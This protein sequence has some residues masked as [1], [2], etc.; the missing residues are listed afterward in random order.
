MMLGEN[1]GDLSSYCAREAFGDRFY[2]NEDDEDDDSKKEATARHNN[3]KHKAIAGYGLFQKK[4]ARTPAQE[5]RQFLKWRGKKQ[6][7]T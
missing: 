4:V 6:E 2:D 7:K 3:K 1:K 5:K